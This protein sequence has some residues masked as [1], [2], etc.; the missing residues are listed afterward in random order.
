LRHQLDGAE[1]IRNIVFVLRNLG[2]P[3]KYGGA[4][5][6]RHFTNSTFQ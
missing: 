6:E 1:G 3:H 2:L 4:W 5:V